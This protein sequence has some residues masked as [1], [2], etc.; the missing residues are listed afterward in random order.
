MDAAAARSSFSA[1]TFGSSG[2]TQSEPTAKRETDRGG[3]RGRGRK[4]SFWVVCT[5]PKHQN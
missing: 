2:L 4:V 3:E 1:M 5:A